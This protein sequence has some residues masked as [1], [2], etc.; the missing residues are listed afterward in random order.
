MLFRLLVFAFAVCSIRAADEW[1]YLGNETLRLGINKT[2]GACIG[3][4]SAG[5]D[6]PNVLNS[7]DRGRFVQQSYYGDSDGS[8]WGK[9]PWRYNP[10]QGGHYEGKPARVL[11]FKADATTLYS[12]TQPVHWATGV[13]LPEV[14]MEQW[15]TLEGALAHVRF[16]MTY[17][18]GKTHSARHQEIPAFFVEPRLGTLV[19]YDGAEPWTDGAL[20]RKQPNFP[21]ESVKLT[22]HWAAWVDERD[23]GVGLCVPVATDATCYRYGNGVIRKDSCSYIAPLATFSLKPGLVWE[24]DA[25]MTLGTVE[26]I[27]G[28]YGKLPRSKP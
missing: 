16:R 11:E 26:E 25:W 18:G 6:A 24:Y 10:V 28:R 20:T 7:Y 19:F 12:K 5:K 23:W 3:W 17:R 4:L 8:L 14:E 15:I 22:E 1:V 9:N 27:R 2:A 13:D 21:N